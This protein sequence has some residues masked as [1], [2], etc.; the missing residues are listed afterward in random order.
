[1][2]RFLLV[3]LLLQPVIAIAQNADCIDSAAARRSRRPVTA[4]QLRDRLS[5]MLKDPEMAV[6][7][8]SMRI[9]LKATGQVFYE[10][11]PE[12]LLVPASNLKL[13]TTAAALDILGSDYRI[14]TSVLSRSRP[15]GRGR[16]ADLVLYGRGDPAFAS[17]FNNSVDPFA[18]IIRQLQ[19]AGVRSV[20]G[21]LIADESYFKG[22]SLGYGWEW[23]DI[24]WP[25]G[26]QV[27]A[28]TVSDNNVNVEIRPS[29]PG[30]HATITITPD[31]G[32]MRLQNLCDTVA[33]REKREI[34]IHRG[35]ENNLL[36]VWG[37]IP[38]DDAGFQSRISVYQ[39]ARFAAVLFKA[40]L[41]RAGIGV[42]GSIKVADSSLV[43]EAVPTDPQ[44]MVELA[45][46]E[47]PPLRE[48]VRVI[49]K[50]SN[51]LYA[52]QVLRVLGRQR[53]NALLDSD[54]AGLE[55]V[56][57][58]L[59]GAGL[60]ERVVLYDGSGLA[61]RSLVSA[62]ALT[63]LLRYISTRP[64][65]KDFEASL[66]ISGEDGTLSR[67]TSGTDAEHRV[68]AKT[69][70]LANVS[71]LSGFIT[72]AYGEEL[73]FS[74]IVNNHPGGQQKMRAFQDE[75]CR[76]LAAFACRLGDSR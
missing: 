48:L 25:Y 32:Y 52:E 24:Q 41:E 45:Y 64:V 31:V 62:A 75:V 34:G 57:A 61:R 44:Q 10:R 27:S 13:Y 59:E 5:A 55:V 7:S 19:Q 51:N 68:R 29:T 6:S 43:S 49:N 72:T 8:V 1:M 65:A 4:L 39:P 37:Q 46:V 54:A 17:R 23:T 9:Q 53:G 20:E 38:V 76:M 60:R 74:I 33:R 73:V 30:E 42:R 2:K 69:G 36:L 58:W 66:P 35:L 3:I 28:L 18:L 12:R 56:R 16:V 14:R 70:T 15:D 63:S 71:S 26:S 22:A 67:R 11:D 47:S 50:F 40:A 21:D